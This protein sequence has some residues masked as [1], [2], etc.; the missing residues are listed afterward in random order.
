MSEKNIIGSAA[1]P[2]CLKQGRDKTGNHLILFKDGAK[3][4][5]RCGYK[6]GKILQSNNNNRIDQM[7]IKDVLKFPF[8]NLTD[9]KIRADTCRHY[10]VRASLSEINGEV[11]RHFYPITYDGKLVGYKQRRKW[12]NSD[13]KIKN[14]PNL[15][16]FKCF[17]GMIGRMR[18][19]I[20]LFGQIVAPRS[21]KLIITEGELDA[22]AVFQMLFDNS[23]KKH[24]DKYKPAVISLTNG[25]SI[26]KSGKGII[27]DVVKDNK[28]FLL[29]YTEIIL[30]FDQDKVGKALA[31]SL[32][33]WLGINRVKTM[34]FSEKDA[35]DMLVMNKET[36]FISAFWNAETYKPEGF[37]KLIDIKTKALTKPEWGLNW[38]WPSL[39]QYTYG[40]RRGEGIY[41]GSGTKVG[42][43]E[44]LNQLG[45]YII[46]NEKNPPAFFKFEEVPHVSVK[47]MLGKEVRIQLHRPDVIYDES[48]ISTAWD[49]FYYDDVGKQKAFFHNCYGSVRWDDLENWIRHYVVVEGCKDIFIDPLTRL[50]AGMTP[51]ETETELR[52]IAD[53]ISTLAKDLDF[54][55][56]IFCHLLKP[57]SGIDHEHGAIPQSSQ[58]RGSRAMQEC[59]YY[60]IGI[61]RNKYD[62]DIITANTSI[63]HILEDRAFGNTGRVEVFYNKETGLYLESINQERI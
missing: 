58:F 17:K 57:L 35:C 40:R 55:Y 36:E 44:V 38:P 15:G 53:R 7:S 54:T 42:K 14:H 9:R 8:I 34:Q 2:Q 52:K 6:V 61:Q 27:D 50:T 43:S 23:K 32:T 5:N 20:N 31:I 49:S 46:K 29:L 13:F 1:C 4:C 10:G 45:H 18:A 59:C 16:K 37:V 28:E 39:T 56:Y 41:F 30:A 47:R 26:D 63:F 21:T 25:A 60:F 3:Y 12:K 22:L 33:E 11:D 51:G 48:S 19:P 62:D 24:G